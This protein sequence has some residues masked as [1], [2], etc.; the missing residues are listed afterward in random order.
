MVIVKEICSDIFNVLSHE[1]NTKS[2]HVKCVCHFCSNPF[3]LFAV[4]FDQ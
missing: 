2:E 4:D 3:L 1:D